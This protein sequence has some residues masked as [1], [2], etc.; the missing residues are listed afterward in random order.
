MATDESPDPSGRSD[1]SEKSPDQ[2]TKSAD[3]QREPVQ[4]KVE[5]PESLEKPGEK[6]TN[7]QSLAEA[8]D[9]EYDVSPDL[10]ERTIPK[11]FV[12][13]LGGESVYTINELRSQG[14]AAFGQGASAF[15]LHVNATSEPIPF[16]TKDRDPEQLDDVLKRHARAGSDARLRDQLTAIGFACLAGAKGTG[17]MSSALATLARRFGTDR[18]HEIVPTQTDDVNLEEL[19]RRRDIVG[20]GHGYLLNLPDT[21]LDWSDVEVLSKIVHKRGSGMIL[22]VAAGEHLGIDRFV[23]RQEPPLTSR[24]FW[25]HLETQTDRRFCAQD[26]RRCQGR[27]GSCRERLLRLCRDSALLT[28]QLS[29]PAA[30]SRA[31]DLATRIANTRPE[32]STALSELL[33]DE[34]LDKLAKARELLA[35]DSSENTIERN[36]DEHRRA[37]RIAYAVFM[38][39]SLTLVSDAA[40]LL[41]EA[42]NP[43]KEAQGGS[44]GFGEVVSHLVPEMLRGSAT[45]QGMAGEELASFNDD[46]MVQ[47]LLEVAWKDYSNSRGVLLTWLDALV[48][49][50]RAQ[51]RQR[52]AVT[53]A[54]F[55]RFAPDLVF[56]RLIDKWSCSRFARSRQA[57]GLAL[58]VA[59]SERRSTRYVSQRV[60]WW[61]QGD[62]G[63]RLDTVARA[64]ISGLGEYQ[65]IHRALGHIDQVARDDDQRGTVVGLAMTQLFNMGQADVVAKQLNWVHEKVPQLSMHAAVTLPL[66]ADLNMPGANGTTP[67]L[68][69]WMGQESKRRAELAQLW[70][71]SLLVPHT[72]G[73]AWKTLG[74]WVMLAEFDEF[75]SDRVVE[76][77]KEICRDSVFQV[78]LKF[79]MERVWTLPDRNSSL[80]KRLSDI[81]EGLNNDNAAV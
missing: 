17:R 43:S 44:R 31:V 11:Q 33:S 55:A 45:M 4:P 35:V 81:A 74:S 49:D 26:C 56:S 47:A 58:A 73:K 54:F 7:S 53:A 2:P 71:H 25:R 21:S 52:A 51:V 69:R 5:S 3:P 64:Y 10:L 41:M 76:L 67:T 30:P 70:R 78:R 60:S 36:R 37:Y 16:W 6:G 34:T 1:S 23:I 15:S 19:I 65:P 38:D 39:C 12:R 50:P 20:A 62:D 40:N 66:I 29:I 77:M 9:E 63:L 22:L 57:A 59:M 79:Y 80:T 75:L 61:T 28:R 32:S 27:Q 72:A 46:D 18:V 13:V 24:V 14:A 48:R 42:Q 68:L 8:Q